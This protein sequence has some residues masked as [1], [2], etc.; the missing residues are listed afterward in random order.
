MA[1]RFVDA[2]VLVYYR[3]RREGETGYMIGKDGNCRKLS[4]ESKNGVVWRLRT[5]LTFFCT[6]SVHRQ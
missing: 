6:D 1:E 3:W 5:Q 4:L 2:K